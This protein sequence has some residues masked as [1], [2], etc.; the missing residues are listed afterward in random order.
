[1]APLDHQHV[2]PAAPP[3]TGGNAEEGGG[4]ILLARN[5]QGYLRAGVTVS[6]LLGMQAFQVNTAG[7]E[8]RARHWE[9]IQRFA[10]GRGRTPTSVTGKAVPSHSP[11]QEHQVGGSH[12]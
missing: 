2:P 5:A 1:M 9:E 12:P 6:R 11:G 7:T 4:Q 3:G 10:G 8:P